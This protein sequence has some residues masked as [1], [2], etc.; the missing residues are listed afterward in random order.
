MTLAEESGRKK[1]SE[2][3]DDE[4]TRI[5]AGGRN[6]SLRN[7]PLHLGYWFRY[8]LNLDHRRSVVVIAFVT[9]GYLSMRGVK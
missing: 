1:Q 6:L 5:A 3:S 9:L 7:S 2:A 8:R 4:E